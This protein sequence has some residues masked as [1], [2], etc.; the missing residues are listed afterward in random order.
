MATHTKICRSQLFQSCPTLCNPMDCSLPGSSVHG[1]FQAIVLKWIAISFSRG[2]SQARDQT[3]VS[4][5]VDRPSEPPTFNVYSI[6]NINFCFS[7]CLRL[8]NPVYFWGTSGKAQ[9]QIKT[10][11]DLVLD[12]FLKFVFKRR[13][14]WGLPGE[15]I[16]L[17]TG[18][19][20]L[21][22]VIVW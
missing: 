8:D 11:C 21:Q 14:H 3:W 19:L 15:K 4:R 7:V 5:I 2:S 18:T 13:R 1:I 22:N 20:C 10:W 17:V 9:K 12:F 6:S 16:C